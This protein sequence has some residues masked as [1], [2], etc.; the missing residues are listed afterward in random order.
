MEC[1]CQ[2]LGF[3]RWWRRCPAASCRPEV[4]AGRRD[5]P[6]HTHAGPG[7]I[8]GGIGQHA[9]RRCNRGPFT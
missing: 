5:A 8:A 1:I 9:L 4:A 7:A 6:L 2:K 3:K